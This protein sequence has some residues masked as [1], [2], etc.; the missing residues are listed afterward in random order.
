MTEFQ[1]IEA[2]SRSEHAQQALARLCIKAG[3]NLVP[4]QDVVIKAV[5]VDQAPLARAIAD[6]AYRAGARLVS[7]VYWDSWVK[8]SRL[9]HAPTDTLHI[10][11]DWWNRHIEE[12]IENGGAYIGLSGDPDLSLFKDIDLQRLA[13]DRLPWTDAYLPML[14]E[15][16]VNWT[17]VPGPTTGMAQR[18]FGAPD[19]GRLWEELIPILRLDSEAPEQAWNEHIARLEGRSAAL[20]AN[21]LRKLHFHGPGTDLHVGLLRASRWVTVG[22]ELAS[23]KRTIANIPSEE[24]FTAPD[25]HDVDG[26]V[27]VTRPVVITGGAMVDGLVLRFEGG[28]IVEVSAERNADAIRALISTDD[29]A[30]RLGE[31]AL[32]DRESP[33]ANSGL[34]FGDVLLDENA[35]SHI[36]IGQAYSVSVDGLVG[37]PAEWVA[38]GVNVSEIH[39]D[40]M[41]GGPEVSVDGIDDR[42]NVVP[43]IRDDRW[44]LG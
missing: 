12:C 9:L 6:E 37:D 14:Y 39:Q 31:V 21:R 11:P 43:V 22:L 10:V 40:I 1:P 26:V 35:A 34:F 8:R 41:I 27:T 4:G 33:V 20:S 24:V 42:E 23:G 29:G 13:I 44:V 30:S 18:I 28:R 3:V 16:S 32:V 25:C 7:V 5:D 38:Q 2:P 36:A 19:V 17:V 15:N